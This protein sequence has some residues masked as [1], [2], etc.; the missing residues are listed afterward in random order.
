VGTVGG[1]A[2]SAEAQQ[3]A[4][5]SPEASLSLAP[6]VATVAWSSIGAAPA[7]ARSGNPVK[8]VRAAATASKVST[9]IT[10]SVSLMRAAS[11]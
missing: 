8:Q 10:P 3:G 1:I 7:D 6:T 5:A 9:R 2:A 4:I 11:R